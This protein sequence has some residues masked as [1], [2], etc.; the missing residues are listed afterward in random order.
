MSATRP[1]YHLVLEK[2]AKDFHT[3]WSWRVGRGLA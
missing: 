2:S 3:V 1:G